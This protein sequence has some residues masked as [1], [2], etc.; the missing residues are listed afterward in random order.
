[1]SALT[2]ALLCIAIGALIGYI[3]AAYT[4]Q[5]TYVTAERRIYTLRRALALIAAESRHRHGCTCH[6]TASVILAEDAEEVSAR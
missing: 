3:T 5:G 6:R 2:A 4:A 1:M